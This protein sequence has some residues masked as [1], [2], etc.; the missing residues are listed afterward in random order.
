MNT[1]HTRFWIAV[2]L[3]ITAATAGNAQPGA[4][5]PTFNATGYVVHTI[6]STW[7]YPMALFVS[8]DGKILTGGYKCDTNQL[9]I[10]TT[11]IILRY[12]PDGTPDVGFGVNG[13]VSADYSSSALDITVQLDG[14]ILVAGS[15]KIGS[16]TKGNFTIYRLNPDGSFDNSFGEGGIVQ[17][18][19]GNFSSSVTLFPDGKILASGVG[20]TTLGLK[21]AFYL[22]KKYNPDG[23]PDMTFGNSGFITTQI[24]NCT[25]AY[26]LGMVMQADDKILLGDEVKI[27]RNCNAM[28]RYNPDGSLDQGFGTGGIVV[29]SAGLR[30]GNYKLAVQADGKILVPGYVYPT[31]L[32]HPHYSLFR[33]NPDGSRDS[34]FHSDGHYIGEEGAA[35]DITIQQDGKIIL[36]GNQKNDSTIKR[37]IVSRYL[38]SGDP[39]PAFGIEGKADIMIPENPGGMS[40][41]VVAPDGKI[42]TSGY[43]NELLSSTGMLLR[44]NTLTVRLNSFGLGMVESADNASVSISPNPFHEKILVEAAGL[45]GSVINVISMDG[46]LLGTFR[47][48]SDRKSIDVDWLEA[49][50]YLLNVHLERSLVSRRIIKL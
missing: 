35:Y 14:K 12:N 20:Y 34:T 37:G 24:A 13:M 27:G 25:G 43:C 38:P 26:V 33:Y 6:D 49:G 42:V 45:K 30:N 9:P 41:V 2:F 31:D 23:T 1:K 19:L 5:D 40:K 17:D 50:M 36:C 21:T 8:P 47:P 44:R 16:Q 11:L 22:L 46:R 3:A 4:L 39:D 18:T 48:G 29:D 10:I 15:G 7:N 32:S 28:I